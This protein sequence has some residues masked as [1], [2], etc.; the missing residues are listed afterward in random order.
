MD[1]EK[2]PLKGLILIN[3]FHCADSR[4]YF[5]KVYSRSLFRDH[6]LETGLG[7]CYYSLSHRN[8]VRGMHFQ[9]PPADCAKLV[10]VPTGRIL[11][12]AL[13]IRRSSPTYGQYHCVELSADANRALYIP[14]G[15]AHGFL[16]REDSSLVVYLQTDVY[17]RDH[18][19]GIR[20]DSFG[21]DWGV[22]DP[23]VSERDSA[24]VSFADFETPFP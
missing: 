24:F 5:T 11:D 1:L 16:S 21:M 14:P 7:E 3:T 10:F 23:I 2:T 6:G 20:W 12:V 9:V 13:D 4:G 8:V 22:E 17:S 15:F 18:D 19:T